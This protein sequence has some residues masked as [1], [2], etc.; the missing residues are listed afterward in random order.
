MAKDLKKSMSAAI[1]AGDLYYM[2]GKVK[3]L[4]VTKEMLDKWK[5]DN[6]GNYDGKALTAYANAKGKKIKP[7][8][9]SLRPKLRGDSKESKITKT[10]LKPGQK[11]D[12]FSDRHK[13]PGPSSGKTFKEKIAESDKSL[14]AAEDAVTSAKQA[15]AAARVKQREN[16]I[17]GKGATNAPPNL[18]GEAVPGDNKPDRLSP[19]LLAR[20]KA[21]RERQEAMKKNKG[22]MIMK[23]K[24]AAAKMMG[25]GMAK[26]KGASMYNKGGAAKKR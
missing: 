6:K 7:V 20:Q 4:A 18:K 10:K 8:E 22:G 3:M 17:R 21:L 1:K 26:K 9:K 19:A 5:K 23:K 12:L 24:P 11:G 16:I 14:Q 15:I 25:G 13:G 2:K